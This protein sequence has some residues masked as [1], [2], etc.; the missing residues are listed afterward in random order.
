MGRYSQNNHKVSFLHDPLCLWI[1]SSAECKGEQPKNP[2][3]LQPTSFTL[4]GPSIP[5]PNYLQPMQSLSQPQGGDQLI[6]NCQHRRQAGISKPLVPSKCPLGL[7]WLQSCLPSAVTTYT[8]RM[9][10]SA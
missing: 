7:E 10:G 2:Q 4:F 5:T 8:Q 9:L 6:C 1:W 3:V